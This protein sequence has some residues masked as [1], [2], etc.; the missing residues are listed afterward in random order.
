MPPKEKFSSYARGLSKGA[1]KK[2]RQLRTLRVSIDGISYYLLP[3]FLYFYR[4]LPDFTNHYFDS[5]M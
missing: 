2:S 3:F 5:C 1:V 4:P